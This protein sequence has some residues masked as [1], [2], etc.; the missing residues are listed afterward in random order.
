MPGTSCPPSDVVR[1][2]LALPALTPL[3]P[4]SR[5]ARSAPARR[6]KP[7][8]SELRFSLSLAY[9][10]CTSSKRVFCRRSEAYQW[11]F[12]SLS[13]R[14]GRSLEMSAHLLP[15]SSWAFAAIASSSGVHGDFFK[16]GLRWLYHLSRHCFPSLF[17]RCGAMMLDQLR[18][19]YFC[20]TFLSS[21]SS[22][23]VQLPLPL[24]TRAF[25]TFFHCCMQSSAERVGRWSAI[26]SQ[27]SCG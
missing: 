23:T 7:P 8:A 11:F 14:P 1:G 4:R 3:S 13:E 12:T 22:Y 15:C 27:L 6:A 26:R 24:N 18:G 16:A 25:R 17:F 5:L 19:P 2:R 9:A 10:T 20:T 21:S